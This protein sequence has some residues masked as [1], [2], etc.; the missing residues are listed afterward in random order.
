MGCFSQV[1]ANSPMTA[2]GTYRNEGSQLPFSAVEGR[3]AV[4]PKQ[5]VSKLEGRI[6]SK[7]FFQQQP[8]PPT[9][10]F[11]ARG[12][13]RTY[14]PGH[15]RLQAAATVYFRRAEGSPYGSF[16]MSL[17]PTQMSYSQRRKSGR[18]SFPPQPAADLGRGGCTSLSFGPVCDQELFRSDRAVAL[19]RPRTRRTSG[20]DRADA[21]QASLPERGCAPNPSAD[22]YSDRRPS[23]PA[24]RRLNP[25]RG[26]CLLTNPTPP[27]PA[28]RL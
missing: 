7:V 22:R 17:S 9:K 21:N 12:F 28:V 1:A 2:H 18:Q 6:E 3:P 19:R 16:V 26:R 23:Q 14:L 8:V 20:E 15:N 25:A 24:A 11:A 10:Q 27:R 5:K 4:C 13:P